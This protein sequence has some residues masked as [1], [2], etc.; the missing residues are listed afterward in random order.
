MQDAGL[1]LR[2]LSFITFLLPISALSFC[3]VWSII[4]DYDKATYTH[5]EVTEI[6]PSIS[7]VIGGFSPQKFVWSL[8]IAL[9]AGPRFIFSKIYQN[10]LLNYCPSKIRAVNFN[11]LLNTVEILSLMTLSFVPSA[12]LFLVHAVAFTMFLVTSLISMALVTYYI[13]DSRKQR[14]KR[15]LVKLTLLCI[16]LATYFYRRHNDLCE[17]YVYSMFALCEYMVVV[18][19]MVWNWAIIRDFAGYNMVVERRQGE[20]NF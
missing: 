4:I 7:A 20:M 5:C 13:K 11:Y 15:T 14:L 12:E 9:V 2:F 8:S 18:C 19:N 10:Y 6:L 1:S 17:P 3:L 16:L